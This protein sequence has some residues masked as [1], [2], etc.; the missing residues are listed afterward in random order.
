MDLAL[1]SWCPDFRVDGSIDSLLRRAALHRGHHSNSAM[2]EIDHTQYHADTLESITE[3]H[4]KAFSF[5][6]NVLTAQG[7]ILDEVVFTSDRPFANVPVHHITDVNEFWVLDAF[8]QANRWRKK[9]FKISWSSKG[10]PK[11][12]DDAL[13]TEFMSMMAGESPGTIMATW[14]RKSSPDAKGGKIVYDDYSELRELQDYQK[15]VRHFIRGRRLIFTAS[16]YMGLAPWHVQKG[17]KVA[18]LCGCSVPVLLERSNISSSG[19]ASSSVSSAER[20]KWYF[21]GDCFVQ[22]WME[23]EMMKR[24]GQST[25]DAW[26]ALSSAEYQLEIH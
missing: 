9:D 18:I 14:T 16:G 1:P 22:G 3:R 15:R 24:F 13:V 10:I 20:T 2:P 25:E 5:S 11:K 12:G 17:Y 6:S 21:R 19:K 26:T 8:S 4:N 7:V 23:G